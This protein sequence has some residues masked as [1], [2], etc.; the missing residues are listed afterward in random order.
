[1]NK[2]L[3]IINNKKVAIDRE[4]T[5][6]EISII[7]KELKCVDILRN[8]KIVKTSISGVTGNVLVEFLIEN[9][10]VDLLNEVLKD[11]KEN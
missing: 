9:K 1:M 8:S 6:E 7:E 10:N 4:L 3:E 11:E 5:D 2:G